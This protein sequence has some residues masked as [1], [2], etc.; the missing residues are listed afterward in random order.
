MKIKLKLQMLMGVTLIAIGGSIA[1]TVIGFNSIHSGAA[2]W[3]AGESEIRGLT[4][5][6]AS[7]M[8]TIELD[9]TA[10]DTKKVFADAE[11]NISHWSAIV[12]PQFS[13]PETRQKLQAIESAWNT[14]D[15]KSHQAIDLAVHDAKAA[16]DQVT[17]IYHSDFQPFQTSLEQFVA[18]TDAQ[19][20]VAGAAA[21]QAS[22]SVFRTV[23]AVMVATLVL[24]FGWILA[25]SRSIQQALGR[26]QATLQE[27]SHSLDLSKRVPVQ[28]MDEVGIAA[29]AFNHLMDRVVE[30]MTTVRE[31]TESVGV[32]SKQIAAGNI[33]LSSRTE[34]QAASLEQTAASMEELTGTV[35][36]NAEN[37]RQASGLARSAS[38]I[39]GR[40][41]QVV[42]NVVS[43][44]G[45]IKESS[46]KIAEIISLIEGIAFQTNIL[47]LNAAVEAARAGE[48]GRGFAVVAGEVRALAQRASAA[49]KEIKVLIDTSVARVGVGTQLVDQAGV[50]MGEI[51]SAVSRV[52]DIMGEIA[53]ASDEQSKGIDQ[54]GQAVTQMDEVTQQNAALVEQA[55]AAAQS[56]DDQA[57]KLK[58]AVGTFKM[59]ARHGAVEARP[60]LLHAGG[61]QVEPA[62]KRVRSQTPALRPVAP[63]TEAATT[64]GANGGGDWTQF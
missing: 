33:D 61:A 47:A 40:G 10:G 44:M 58:A 30:V 16:N 27:A 18:Q 12:G 38:E 5:I 42:S 39:A 46:S 52:T 20:A 53:A 41:N 60:P 21:K 43:T 19:A 37:A 64:H 8:S 13:A 24:V 51:I 25:L 49:A 3:Q 1:V 48:Q 6:K 22:A 9:P 45:E 34:E 36:Q 28:N 35:R 23:I 17:S 4:E 15:Q 11:Q 62:I 55:A 7:A 2:A 29:T 50:T 26:I 63:D 31:S 32:A 14:Y 57:A 59:Q 56:L 54:V